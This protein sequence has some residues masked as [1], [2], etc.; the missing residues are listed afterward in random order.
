MTGAGQAVAAHPV[1]ASANSC[2]L[3]G[4]PCSLTMMRDS[5]RAHDWVVRPLDQACSTTL[6]SDASTGIWYAKPSAAAYSG[7]HRLARMN[8]ASQSSG[9]GS[10]DRG[11]PSI[12][13]PGRRKA[14]PFP[15]GRV[16]EQDEVAAV[17]ALLGERPRERALLIEYLHLIQDQEGCLPEGHLQALAEELRIPMAEVYEVA[18]FYAHFDV[19]ARRRAAPADGDGARLRQPELHAGRRRAAAGR[20]AGR[21][22]CRACACVRAPCIGSCHTAPAA[23]VGHH[24]VDHATRRQAQGARRCAA[25]CIPRCPPIRTSTPT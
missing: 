16:L 25:R 13:A 24:H 18:T 22:A 5:L 8:D 1:T 15:R 23:E 12:R 3:D 14:A 2:A 4:S 11:A 6:D 10:R 20:A 7:N 17:K 19:V 21:E 9:G